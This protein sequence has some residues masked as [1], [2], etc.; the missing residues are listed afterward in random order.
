MTLFETA[1]GRR[2][3]REGKRLGDGMLTPV[4][5]VEFRDPQG[6]GVEQLRPGR[7]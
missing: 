4:R 3:G 2:G 6:G 5:P 7:D 1:A